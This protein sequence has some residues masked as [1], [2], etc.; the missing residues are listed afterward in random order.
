MFNIGDNKFY[1]LCFSLDI[2]HLD[3]NLS[4]KYLFLHHEQKVN[5]NNPVIKVKVAKRDVDKSN[6]LKGLNPKSY[7]AV[8]DKQKSA[9]KENYE[10]KNSV[11]GYLLSS[12]RSNGKTKIN[13]DVLLKDYYDNKLLMNKDVLL[14]ETSDKNQL[15]FNND[16]L[17]NK[18]SISAYDNQNM[19]IGKNDTSSDMNEI[20]RVIDPERKKEILINS[21][22]FVQS[23]TKDI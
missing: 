1:P 16:F 7:D 3:L 4:K 14:K 21:N 6:K 17:V 2:A 11:F 8:V 18:D 13:E 12:P 5:E 23:N 9:Y 19:V 22:K 20:V 15:I 10:I